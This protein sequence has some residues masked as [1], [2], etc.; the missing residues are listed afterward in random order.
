[1]WYRLKGLQLHEEI[2]KVG[3]DNH[4][5]I[6]N[7]LNEMLKTEIVMRNVMNG[8]LQKIRNEMEQVR[9]RTKEA[10]RDAQKALSKLPGK[11]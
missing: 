2:K 7:V 11:K 10:A 1:M 9:K 5:I 8:E 4:S 6:N 3:F